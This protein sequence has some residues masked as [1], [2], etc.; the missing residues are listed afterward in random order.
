[1]LDDLPVEDL[2][3]SLSRCRVDAITFDSTE[4]WFWPVHKVSSGAKVIIMNWRTYSQW[5]TSATNFN[6]FLAKWSLLYMPLRSS[7][8]LL[9]WNMLLVPLVDHLS[10]GNITRALQEGWRMPQRPL[11]EPA[12][13]LAFTLFLFRRNVLPMEIQAF[14]Q[15]TFD[16]ASYKAYWEEALRRIPAEDR[17]EWDMTKHGARD[18]CAFLNIEGPRCEGTSPLPNHGEPYPELVLLSTPLCLFL[19][20]LNL[21]ICRLAFGCLCRRRAAPAGGKKQD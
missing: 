15:P 3:A 14:F 2:A 12:L 1:M 20:V 18:L 5:Q 4:H 19:H 8:D 13:A 9:P 16:E 7:I 21:T 11:E 17:M 6:F 10:G